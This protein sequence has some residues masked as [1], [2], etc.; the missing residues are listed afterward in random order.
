[1]AKPHISEPATERHILS[2]VLV[3]CD[4]V[5]AAIGVALDHLAIGMAIGMGAPW[6]RKPDESADGKDLFADGPS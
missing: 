5:G 4:A 3:E 2:E 1:M 6:H